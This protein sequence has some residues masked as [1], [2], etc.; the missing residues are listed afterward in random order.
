[1]VSDSS[2]YNHRIVFDTITLSWTFNAMV[3]VKL[4]VYFNCLE[5]GLLNIFALCHFR[6]LEQLSVYVLITLLQPYALSG[7]QS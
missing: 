2:I 7:V 6:F 5:I 3:V 1:M 4:V